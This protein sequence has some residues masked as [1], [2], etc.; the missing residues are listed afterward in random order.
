MRSYSTND[1]RNKNVSV[2]EHLG[3]EILKTLPD[4]I[5]FAGSRWETLATVRRPLGLGHGT[6]NDASHSSN[7]RSDVTLRHVNKYRRNARKC[8]LKSFKLYTARRSLF[9]CGEIKP[10]S[11][12]VRADLRL[13]SCVRS[14][15]S[16][17]NSCVLQRT[18]ER[19]MKGL[20]IGHYLSRSLPRVSPSKFFR[21][22][23][24]TQWILVL[25][26]Q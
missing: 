21:A 24:P 20:T 2:S 25:I 26:L 14:D 15:F 10:V 7:T 18:E 17:T 1:Y 4:P 9:C 5:C 22:D 16:V 6:Y 8:W 12:P 13:K 23:P 19:C 3:S 11:P